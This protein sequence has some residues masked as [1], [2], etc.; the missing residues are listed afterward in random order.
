MASLKSLFVAS[1]PVPTSVNPGGTVYTVG[2]LVPATTATLYGN[3][4]SLGT[5]TVA[6]SGVA[7]WTI[8]KPTKGTLMTYSAVVTGQIGKA[9]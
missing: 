6:G 2:G 3:G 7:T 9:P 5:A 1:V 8:A 4:S